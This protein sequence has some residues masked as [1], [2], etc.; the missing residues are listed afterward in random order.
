MHTYIYWLYITRSRPI[1]EFMKHKMFYYILYNFIQGFYKY[2]SIF[3][4]KHKLLTTG[5]DYLVLRSSQTKF[6]QVKA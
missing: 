6:E 2:L 5:T 4:I 3:E 1:F